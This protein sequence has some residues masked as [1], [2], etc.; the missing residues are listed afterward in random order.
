MTLLRVVELYCGI[1]GLAAAI[2]T[3]RAASPGC[4]EG[5]EC[6]WARVVASV[7]IHQTAISVCRHNFDHAAMV[8]LV[9]GL[10]SDWLRALEADLWWASPP[11]QP[12]T[13]RGRRLGLEDARARTF[14]ALL[15]HVDSVRPCFFALENVV[16]FQ[17]SDA[18]AR[19]RERLA[20]AG[21][22]HVQ[23]RL[24]CPS[25]FGVPNR[26]P[27]FYLVAGRTPLETLTDPVHRLRV[28]ADVL[29]SHIDDP[30]LWVDDQLLI[31]YPHALHVVDAVDP[32]A[33]TSCF[34]SA[35][36]RSP[37]RSGSYLRPRRDD[38]RLRRFSP[39]EILRLL[40]FPDSYRLPPGLGRGVA[41]RLVGNS[42]S[43]EPV[44]HM[45]EAIPRP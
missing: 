20:A 23:E 4:T 16:G 26:R 1:G 30:E 6:V 2:T 38:S 10:E 36:G 7:D 22:E 31:R 21:Y 39:T 9:D 17:D 40:S 33:M 13:R 14:L 5:P 8:K 35:Y 37:V 29:D 24:L 41:W 18:H 44:R 12:F 19:L 32:R 25:E 3:P 45:L 27:R 28:L 34:T 42:L 43:L 11:C 15:D